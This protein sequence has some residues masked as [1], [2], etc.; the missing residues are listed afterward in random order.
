MDHRIISVLFTTSRGITHEIV[1][2]RLAAF[3]QE[4]VTGDTEVG[5]GHLIRD[6]Y[7]RSLSPIGTTHNKT[8]RFRAVNNKGH[9]INHKMNKVL[10]KGKAEVFRIT[11]R[12]GY[13]IK[14]TRNHGFLTQKGYLLLCELSVGDSVMV[15]GRPCLIR[16]SDQELEKLYTQD[17]LSIQEIADSLGLHHKVVYEK[18]NR[19]RIYVKG[20]NGRIPW[21]R[22]HFISNLPGPLR[23][24]WKGGVAQKYAVKLMRDVKTCD[25]CNESLEEKCEIHHID[26]NRRNNSRDNLLKLCPNCHK[27]LHFGWKVGKKIHLDEI[28]EIVPAGIEDVYDMEMEAPY[29][30]YIANGFVVHNST[31]FSMYTQERF[32]G[33]ITVIEPSWYRRIGQK[34]A[35]ATLSEDQHDFAVKLLNAR[36]D[37][38][39]SSCRLT[40]ESYIRAIEY[41]PLESVPQWLIDAGLEILSKGHSAQEARGHL[42][43]ELRANIL[44]TADLTE[45]RH[46]FRQRTSLGAHPDFRELANTL[47]LALKD[48]YPLFFEDLKFHETHSLPSYFTHENEVTTEHHFTKQ[49][50]VESISSVTAMDFL[51]E[52]Y[53]DPDFCCPYCSQD[54]HTPKCVLRRFLKK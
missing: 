8:A 28:V 18:L 49:I 21:N 3:T 32:D 15:N 43:N 16:I 23:P 27:K 31:R 4:C 45:W 19:M 35:M 10:Y 51:E 13:S 12:L 38:W 37:E 54:P 1:R 20:L 36:L 24:N 29:H 52:I 34:I 9:I 30:N 41:K 39:K 2:H 33:E 6:L 48:M 14:T 44:M 25:I 17:K 11:T 40:E 7:N 47:L 22:G 42:G 46:V 50:K 53:E 5:R 26:E